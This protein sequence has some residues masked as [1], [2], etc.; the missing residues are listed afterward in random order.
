MSACPD[1]HPP[2]DIS[3][4]NTNGKCDLKCLFQFNYPPSTCT[5][6][7]RR[8]YLALDYDVSVAP[9]VFYNSHPYKVSEVRIYCPSV[10]TFSGRREGAE[11]VVFHTTNTGQP[12]LIVC[13]PIRSGAPNDM[14]DTIVNTVAETAPS[15][16]AS[17]QVNMATPF[18]LNKLVPRKPFYAYTGKSMVQPCSSTIT[19]YIVYSPH[20]ESAFL[21]L[22]DA[23]M[24]LLETIVSRHSYVVNTGPSAP[25]LFF[26]ERGPQSGVA[27]D[28]I[29]ID[30][31]PVDQYE[32]TSS[33]STSSGSSFPS[34]HISLK[35]PVIQV[36]LS[37][38]LCVALFGVL[39][40]LYILLMGKTKFSHSPVFSKKPRTLETQPVS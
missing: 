38:V 4:T 11:L 31:Q 22:S 24:T 16:G 14:L 9:P 6:T 5:A 1:T 36:L 37:F 19:E 18:T 8:T 13:V 32:D 26:N 33:G 40:G 17:T 21:S 20:T 30:C 2:I 27:G 35:S 23:G 12:P 39:K 3:P 29:Y 34:F 7:H 25:L 15:E 28:D 10:H